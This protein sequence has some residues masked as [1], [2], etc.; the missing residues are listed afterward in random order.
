LPGVD[1]DWRC[2]ACNVI[3]A[4]SDEWR[5]AVV[6]WQDDTEQIKGMFDAAIA[7]AKPAHE[8]LIDAAHQFLSGL[9]KPLFEAGKPKSE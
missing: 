5:R 1:N 2:A 3:D 6:L 7:Y 9:I 8:R 4:Q